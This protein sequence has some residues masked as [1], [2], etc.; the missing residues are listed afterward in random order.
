[1]YFHDVSAWASAWQTRHDGS[2]KRLQFVSHSS[3][4]PPFA[5]RKIIPKDRS[6]FMSL[7]MDNNGIQCRV[8][9][10]K[11]TEKPEGKWKMNPASFLLY[12]PRQDK[13]DFCIE[14]KSTFSSAENRDSF[15]QRDILYAKF[16]L[17]RGEA[18]K[19]VWFRV[20]KR[21]CHWRSIS[22]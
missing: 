9:N 2:S 21:L 20:S 12:Y 14:T 6:I 15:F 8:V 13:R 10:G 17:P 19:A 3:R 5:L 7:Q 1:M 18:L 16:M 11:S 4:L 22:L